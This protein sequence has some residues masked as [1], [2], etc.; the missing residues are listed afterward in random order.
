MVIIKSCQSLDKLNESTRKFLLQNEFKSKVHPSREETFLLAREAL[1]L[2]LCEFGKFEELHSIILKNYHQLEG[3][4]EFTLSLSHTEKCG[5]AALARRSDF[6]A[7]GIDVE[8]EDRAV[9]DE[10]LQKISHPDDLP[11]RNIVLWILKEAAFKCLSNS[12]ALE[13]QP[14]FTDI[15]IGQE[16]WSH[17]P[18]G[19]TGDWEIQN[20]K[21]YLI[22]LATLNN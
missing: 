5:V 16:S 1:R 20:L 9:R 4:P 3:H 8:R 18:S 15:Q 10:L 6:L 12:A 19:L 11:L 13:K 21:P 22:G 7:L 17:S 14:L 2:A